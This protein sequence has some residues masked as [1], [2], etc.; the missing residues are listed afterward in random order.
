MNNFDHFNPSVS[1]SASPN[2]NAQQP[3]RRSGAANGLGA[4]AGRNMQSMNAAFQ[5]QQQMG[6]G[7]V[8]QD[9][10]DHEGGRQ[11]TNMQYGGDSDSMDASMQQAMMDFG[12]SPSNN[13]LS[14]FTFDPSLGGNFDSSMS[15]QF[16]GQ[17]S[18]MQGQNNASGGP[19]SVN[20]QYPN[21]MD[22]NALSAA[23]AGFP[24]PYDTDMNNN[25]MN[26]AN[27]MQMGLNMMNDEDIS[28]I[29]DL[30]S[31]QQ[32]GSPSFTSPLAS[33][34]GASIY[35]QSQDPRGQMR[36]A[37]QGNMMQPT[38]SS[39]DFVG[40]QMQAPQT[41]DYNKSK[42]L[43]QTVGP[44]ESSQPM[45]PPPASSSSARKGKSHTSGSET[46]GGITLPWSTP[47]GM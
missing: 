10:T 23:S 31:A 15:G 22:Y 5:S 4:L 32:F 33:T 8:P 12:P 6:N 41:S 18:Q 2:P 20:T 3:R 44:T 1:D 9:Q 27:N 16:N 13:S 28:V 45:P 24:S 34:F 30:F 21:M 11:T 36:T 26:N 37:S 47:A 19:L 25:Y 35:G 42:Q 17:M 39:A 46:I 7:G 40:N 29:N 43:E 14:Q 38:S